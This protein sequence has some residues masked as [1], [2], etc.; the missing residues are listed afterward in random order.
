MKN[1]LEINSKLPLDFYNQPLLDIAK[2]ILGKVFV[3]KIQNKIFAGIIVEVEAYDGR[4][5]KAA[6]SYRGIT[7]RNKVMFEEGG[8]IYVYFIYGI[9]HCCNV[10]TGNKGIGNAILIRGIEPVLGIETML[11]NRFGNIKHSEKHILSVTNGPAKITKAFGIDK[12]NNG[13]S[14]CGNEIYLCDS[15]Y[16]KDFKIVTTTRIGIKKSVDLPW[17]F[18]IKNNPY[19]SKK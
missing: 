1:S 5:D 7:S 16:P 3:R 9:H 6:H 14:L 13:T 2:E 12:N 8:L 4:T 10:V 18:Y 15:N 17:R 19:V 11:Q